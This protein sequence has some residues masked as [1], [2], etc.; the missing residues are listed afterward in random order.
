M[1]RALFAAPI[2]ALAAPAA[3]TPRFD[4][5]AAAAVV[6]RDD[7]QGSLYDA[8]DAYGAR[9]TVEIP[10][11]LPDPLRLDAGLL[12]YASGYTQGTRAV[13]VGTSR[14]T[15]AL[16]IR[17]GWELGWRPFRDL[18]LVPYVSG[19]FATTLTSTDYLVS[20]PVGV[21]LGVKPQRKAATGWEHGAVYG[22]GLGF[23]VPSAPVGFTGRLEVLRLRRGVHDDLTLGL[24]LGISL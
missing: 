12:W 13:Q 24:G 14:H 5:E 18:R 3:A 23:A 15:L 2:L 11:L 16:P 6:L 10:G 8:E 9:A 20:D 19:G 1:M 21:E 7:P 4:I 22:A 17:A